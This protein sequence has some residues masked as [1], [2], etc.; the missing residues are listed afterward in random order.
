MFIGKLI[1][2]IK[3]IAPT[4]GSRIRGSYILSVGTYPSLLKI[5]KNISGY[6]EVNTLAKENGIEL[7]FKSQEEY[8][9]FLTQVHKVG[10]YEG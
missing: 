5:T 9:N 2:T 8:E 6:L 3:K 7:I 4:R 1:N 10:L